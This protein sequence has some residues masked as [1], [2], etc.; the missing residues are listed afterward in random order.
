MT[1]SSSLSAAVQ[2]A[3]SAVKVDIGG[4]SASAIATPASQTSGANAGAEASSVGGT[5]SSSSGIGSSGKVPIR[6]PLPKGVN[7][8][9]KAGRKL[10]PLV[11]KDGGKL[12][13][14]TEVRRFAI[15]M[16]R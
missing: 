7:D 2:A 6:P 8:K 9:G 4:N 13:I 5:P 14:H 3:A 16:P 1:S 10:S 12:R 15:N 11:T